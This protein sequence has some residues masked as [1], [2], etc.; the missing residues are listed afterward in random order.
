M[1]NPFHQDWLRRFREDLRTGNADSLTSNVE[2][3]GLEVILDPEFCELACQEDDR[4][5]AIL[6]GSLGEANSDQ[7]SNFIRLRATYQ[8]LVDQLDLATAAAECAVHDNR[9]FSFYESV[10]NAA[11][12]QKELQITKTFANVDDLQFAL[13][14]QVNTGNSSSV[15]PILKKWQTID[16]SDLPWLKAC[17]TIVKRGESNVLKGEALRLATSCEKLIAIA[18]KSQN[19]VAQEM[20]IQW[21]IFA[22]KGKDGVVA[23]EAATQAYRHAPDDE[24]RFSL[25]KALILNGQNEAALEHLRGLLIQSLANSNTKENQA[26]KSQIGGFNVLA[27][28][29]ALIDI[30]NHLKKKGLK[31][32]LMSGTLLG[33]AR[34]GELL[35]HDKDVDIG[36]IGWENQFTVAEA[37]LEAGHYK[38]DLTQLTGHNRFLMSAQDLKNGMAIDIFLFH[39][40][41]DHFLHGIDFDMNF[42]QNFK[43]SKFE[44]KEIEFLDEN[45]YVPANIDQN[46]KENY[47]DWKTPAPSYVV[48]V[49]SPALCDTPETRGILIYMEILKTIVKGMKPQRIN[50]ILD[51]LESTR[52][53]ILGLDAHRNLR[54][55]CNKQ[56]EKPAPEGV[57]LL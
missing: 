30:N 50:R 21:A 32:F 3:A 6:I 20:R 8:H 17:R 22:Y 26:I 46:L 44:L 43:F 1:N 40:K 25:A 41:D 10:L 42:T 15:F 16:K 47:G 45:F 14:L 31:P 37:L 49:E 7:K 29:D 11:K 52:N 24:R 27:A 34:Q 9:S 33:Y 12:T 51:H 19:K 53:N 18:P 48:T 23:V 56:L 36:I 55:W 13:Q 35:A 2:M 5:V 4:Q 57:I 38:L 39:E 54:V 28:E